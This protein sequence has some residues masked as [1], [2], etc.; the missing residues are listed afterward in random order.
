MISSYHTI[1]SD[2]FP[3]FL[4]DY[5]TL[6][7]LQRL[8]GIGLFC[9]ILHSFPS[10][11]FILAMTTVQEQHSLF[12]ILPMTKNK[13]QQDCF[14]MFHLLYSPTQLIS[15]MEI[16]YIRTPL[17][18]E[19]YRFQNKILCSILY[20]NEMEFHLKKFPIINVILSQIIQDH[21]YL[22][23]VQSIHLRLSFRF[24]WK[25]RY[26]KKYISGLIYQSQ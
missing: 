5:L 11:P 24:T 20:L 21:N 4:H 16:I 9:G 23:T 10:K 25:Y 22:P 18:K 19:I 15:L 3:I 13:L 2:D 14:M 8:K 17:R 7:I 26:L 6:D 12:G 1:L